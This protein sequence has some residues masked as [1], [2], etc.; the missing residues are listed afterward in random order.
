[1]FD[2]AFPVTIA[3]GVHAGRAVSV[4]EEVEVVAG[5]AGGNPAFVVVLD[6]VDANPASVGLVADGDTQNAI[7]HL[8]L[9]ATFDFVNRVGDTVSVDGTGREGE[10]D[11]E[12]DGFHSRR[13]SRG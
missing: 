8:G 6:C 9:G 1:M 4:G 7:R 3:D 12:E 13:N 11:G 10:E 2:V 5:T